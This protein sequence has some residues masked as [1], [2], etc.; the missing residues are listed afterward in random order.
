MKIWPLVILLL[1]APLV[2]LYVLIKVGGVVG[3]GWTLGLVISTAVIGLALVR[4]Q[5][6]AVLSR[7]QQTL[8][9]GEVPALPLL[10]GM[11]LFV[12]GAFLL[13]PGFLTDILGFTL[14]IPPIRRGLIRFFVG[15]FLVIN[16]VPGASKPRAQ[17]GG[18]VIL[19][20]ESQRLDRDN[21]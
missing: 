21:H 17:D 14:L 1:S 16:P 6:F 12:A 4:I 5:G 20:G 10:E 13:F 8:A 7:I 19:E 11:A 18:R 15:Y 2:E 3:A 9:R